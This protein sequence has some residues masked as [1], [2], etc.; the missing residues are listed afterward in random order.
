MFRSDTRGSTR[1][2][3]RSGF[4]VVLALLAALLVALPG[5]GWAER[6]PPPSPVAFKG[7]LY[8]K[9]VGTLSV[10][11]PWETARVQTEDIMAMRNV[12]FYV[13]PSNRLPFGWDTQGLGTPGASIPQTGRAAFA[14]R[15]DAESTRLIPPPVCT[16]TTLVEGE[17][18][19]A[20]VGDYPG[21]G[22]TIEFQQ[23]LSETVWRV[24]VATDAQITVTDH[25]TS[26]CG[27]RPPPTTY[28]WDFGITAEG[29]AR[30]V[31]RGRQWQLFLSGERTYNP[32]PDEPWVYTE[33]LQGTLNSVPLPRR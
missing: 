5:T 14:I 18:E 32:Y 29:T 31:R 21:P 16:E 26:T 12:V 15:N 22:A 7:G 33:T 10:D 13:R 6:R 17:A 23:R 11:K 24:R 8:M 28:V 1:L 20:R 3:G 19:D 25:W 30:L 9:L 27:E 2:P 4:F